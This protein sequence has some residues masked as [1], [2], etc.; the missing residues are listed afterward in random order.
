M[1]A[2]TDGGGLL[3]AVG[4]LV[5]GDVCSG[6]GCGFAGSTSPPDANALKLSMAGCLTC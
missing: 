4:T 3:A 1:T 5:A 2:G 6:V